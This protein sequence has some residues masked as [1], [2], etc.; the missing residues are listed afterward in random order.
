MRCKKE[1]MGLAALMVVL[2]HFYIPFG[3]SAF[4]TYIYRSTFIGVDLFFFVSSYSIAS[5]DRNQKFQAKEF[6]L[7]RLE[8]IYAP[9]VILSFIA[10]V[11]HNWSVSRFVNII[12]GVEFYERGG[13]AFLWYFI[14]IMVFYLLVPLILLLKRETKLLGFPIL[15]A[16]W[17]V[18]SLILQFG[19]NYTKAFILINRLPI[20][21]IGLYYDELIL[22]NLNK[23]KKN[24][25]CII[26]IVT[27]V[28]GTI[29]VYKYATTVR[30]IKPFMDMYYVIA[31]PLILA[32]VMVVNSLV[33]L[34][35][36]KY[37]SSFLKFIG[38][39]TLELYGLQMIF[40]YDIE[41]KLLKIVPLKQLAFLGT[42][43]VLIFMAFV[44]NRLFG[45][46]HKLIE[47]ER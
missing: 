23:L 10:T 22:A 44:F 40:G 1:I 16:L 28:V 26:E 47:K 17:I 39:I 29:L 38:G 35:K 9:F 42:V 33:T 12:L 19:F 3:T 14:G 18:L 15:I 31:I 24:H 45:I 36:D 37:E 46:A 6:I 32:T 11:Y 43:V 25:I 5:R 7:N 34:L 41:M 27:F 20:F 8:Y 21:F 13:G 30:V 4:E 2:F